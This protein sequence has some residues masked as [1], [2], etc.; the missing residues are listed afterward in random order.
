MGNKTQNYFY[1]LN[2]LFSVTNLQTR[3]N[4]AKAA[5]EL[6]QE[7]RNEGM[8]AK[9]YALQ[10]RRGYRVEIV[11]TGKCVDFILGNCRV[12][13]GHHQLNSDRA[14]Y[15]PAPCDTCKARIGCQ[16]ECPDFQRYVIDGR[17]AQ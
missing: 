6:M 5:A 16:V 9:R 2:R 3:E 7:A 1:A 12:A 14:A 17:V 13:A 11:G 15:E 8:V 4:A 10:R